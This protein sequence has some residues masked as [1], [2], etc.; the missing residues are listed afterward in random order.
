MLSEIKSELFDGAF[1]YIENHERSIVQ[2][3]DKNGG[4]RTTN[5]FKV[6]DRISHKQYGNGIIIDQ[7]DHGMVTIEFISMTS[8]RTIS[9]TKLERSVDG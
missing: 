2:L 6:G 1:N 7:S 4:K 3:E 5:E 8:P 9:I